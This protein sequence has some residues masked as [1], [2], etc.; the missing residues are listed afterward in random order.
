VHPE[1]LDLVRDSAV[2]P[3]AADVAA[4]LGLR[5]STARSR[6]DRLVGAGLVV[7]ARAS[8]GLPRRPP[9]RY[10]AMEPE[11]PAGTYRHLLAGLL[12]RSLD[13]REETAGVGVGWGRALAAA[14]PRGKDPATTVVAVLDALG[15]APRAAGPDV[16]L[17]ACPYLELV[18]RN[19]DAMCGVHAGIVG[20]VLEATGGGTAALE[21]FAAPGACVVRL[22]P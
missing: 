3:T 22:R 8:T 9:W 20:G 7:K 12:D 21:P 4:K 18:R 17:T 2:G 1:V 14:H 6:L 13:T 15:F 19:P 16:H 11:P 10:R 5:L